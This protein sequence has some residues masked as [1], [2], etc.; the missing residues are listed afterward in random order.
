MPDPGNA[1]C[2]RV[3]LRVML[4]GVFSLG[5]LMLF[6]AQP[7]R[8]YYNWTD[9]I[10]TGFYL[11]KSV[12]LATDSSIPQELDRIPLRYGDLLTY[13]YQA[14]AWA[15]GRYPYET[16]DT[17]VKAVGALP[18]DRLYSVKN[19]H[20]RCSG[21]TTANEPN[22]KNCTVIAELLTHDRKG[23]RLHW[24]TYTG[25][26]IPMDYV[27]MRGTLSKN[28][29]DSRYYGLVP[30]QRVTGVATKL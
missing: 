16:G 1:G 8:L 9:S 17:F 28:T 6:Q 14:P 7:Y 21:E 24:V 18:G 25:D 26:T 4:V 5:A 11:V 29:Y 15:R 2:T 27:Y 22:S 20:V 19:T 23:R 13:T 3:L 12:K 10:P 30:A